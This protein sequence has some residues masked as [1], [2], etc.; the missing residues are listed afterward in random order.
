MLVAS[1]IAVVLASANHKPHSPEA[2]LRQFS[3]EFCVKRAARVSRLRRWSIR[4]WQL[5]GN[6]DGPF[7]FHGEALPKS[8]SYSIQTR[9][10]IRGGDASIKASATEYVDPKAHSYRDSFLASLY[11]K[12]ESLLKQTDIERALGAKLIFDGA[13]IENPG[14]IT[15]S[16]G[17]EPTRTTKPYTRWMQHYNGSDTFND[18]VSIT[19]TRMWGNI[20]NRQSWYISCGSYRPPI[21][22][23][24]S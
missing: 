6:S 4:N 24:G 5:S 13:I 23:G 2:V 17:G 9:G 1:V 8:N 7:A 3:Q 21:R 14:I 19:A 16:G 12:P 22:R 11:V 20:G 15:I 18:T 10:M